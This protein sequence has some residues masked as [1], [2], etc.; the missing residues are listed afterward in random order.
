[1]TDVV[2]VNAP[3]GLH[4]GKEI[5]RVNLL[6]NGNRLAQS[7]SLWVARR[8]NVAMPSRASVSFR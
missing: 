7:R 1:M 3:F 2:R 5:V 8:R 6:H 4:A